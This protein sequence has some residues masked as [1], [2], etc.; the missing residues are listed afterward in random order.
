MMFPML[1]CLNVRREDGQESAGKPM[2]RR[3]MRFVRRG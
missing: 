1:A 2:D 3:Q